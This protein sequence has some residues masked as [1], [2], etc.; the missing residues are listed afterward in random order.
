VRELDRFVRL[1][2]VESLLLLCAIDRKSCE[3]IRLAKTYVILKWANMVEEQ[4]DVSECINECVQYLRRNEHGMP[5]GSSDEL[6]EKVFLPVSSLSAEMMV[7]IIDFD[8][9]D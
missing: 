7:E 8:D 4:E 2:L 9:V 1:Y 5:E 3:T 6:V